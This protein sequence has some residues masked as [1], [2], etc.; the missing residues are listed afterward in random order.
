[1]SVMS[2][3][4]IS[5]G[6]KQL[7]LPLKS[8][9]QSV[10]RIVLRCPFFSV[11]KSN[12][13]MFISVHRCCLGYFPCRLRLMYVNLSLSMYI[14][15]YHIL[16]TYK[17]T[18][19]CTKYIYIYIYIYIYMEYRCR[20]RCRSLCICVDL[21]QISPSLLGITCNKLQVLHAWHVHLEHHHISEQEPKQKNAWWW[22]VGGC[23][24]HSR[25]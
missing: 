22:K 2:D 3:H 14:Y 9:H 1:M 7:A 4:K 16:Y 23:A 17:M 20:C 13:H 18:Q 10:D 11:R 21:L 6:S 25:S 24:I 12:S 19:I 15:I 8:Y 5:A